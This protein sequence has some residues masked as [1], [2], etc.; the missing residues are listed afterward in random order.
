MGSRVKNQCERMNPSHLVELDAKLQHIARCVA[1]R[2][3]TK[4][5]DELIGMARDFMDTKDTFQRVI[6]SLAV[7]HLDAQES[8]DMEFVLDG[9][10]KSD[11]ASQEGFF[12]EM[13]APANRVLLP[14]F[15]NLETTSL[16]RF[17]TFATFLTPDSI[18]S[19]VSGR[20]HT[21]SASQLDFAVSLLDIP[22]K[23]ESK[24]IEMIRAFGKPIQGRLIEKYPHVSQE[25]NAIFEDDK[26]DRLFNEILS[27]EPTNKILERSTDLSRSNSAE[28][29]AMVLTKLYCIVPP[30]DAG[31]HYFDCAICS[32]IGTFDND[33]DSPRFKKKLRN[34]KNGW[35]YEHSCKLEPICDVCWKREYD[36]RPHRNGW[37]FHKHSSSSYHDIETVSF[38][39]I[40]EVLKNDPGRLEQ[41]LPR[42]SKF[43]GM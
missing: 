11:D 20:G 33:D 39:S 17:H 29:I 36:P 40:S 24:H 21:L 4:S 5:A 12:R 7:K 10:V 2:Q 43:L 25:G 27:T 6:K 34:L 30:I 15:R 13:F 31:D 28:N 42:L 37:R 32:R 14:Q 18:K 1:E 16:E 19:I 3:H 9:L 22:A 38:E 26:F 8:A 35:S 41:C 23:I